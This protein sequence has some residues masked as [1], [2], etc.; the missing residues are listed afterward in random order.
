MI[1]K[2]W[3]F[4]L[5]GPNPALTPKYIMVAAPH[6]SN[7]DFP[8]G[9][10]VKFMWK[11]PINWLGKSSLFMPPYG[12]IFK[13]LGGV[14]VQRDKNSNMV[15]GIVDIIKQRSQFALCIAPE[16][17]RSYTEKVKS[18]FYHIARGA[19]IPIITCMID[20]STKSLTFSP[21]IYLTDMTFQ[22]S[23][24]FLKQQFQTAVAKFPEKTLF[25]RKPGS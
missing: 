7:W 12:F 18:G 6:T 20:Y 14:S 25:G 22:E 16:G 19:D 11:V 23:V 1:M 17:T 24:D 2:L 5:R 21:P 13:W 9:I 10:L 4:E 15:D 3:G 8:L